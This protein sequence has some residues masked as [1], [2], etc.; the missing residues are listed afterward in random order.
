MLY[1]SVLVAP[2]SQWSEFMGLVEVRIIWQKDLP[3][4]QLC[5]VSQAHSTNAHYQLLVVVHMMPGRWNYCI[6]SYLPSM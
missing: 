1:I 5:L 3:H 6:E 2:A 4:A